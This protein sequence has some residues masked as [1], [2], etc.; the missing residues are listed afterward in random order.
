MQPK[1]IG[2]VLVKSYKWQSNTLNIF[3]TAIDVKAQHFM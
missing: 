1:Q 2:F 3:S